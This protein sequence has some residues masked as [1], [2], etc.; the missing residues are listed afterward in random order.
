MR[1]MVLAMALLACAAARADGNLL[2]NAG[3][4]EE[5]TPAWEKRTPDDGQRRIRRVEG[6]GRSGA[7]V[8]LESAAPGQTRL[9]QGHGR[10]IS[11]APGSVVEL[12]AWVR[13]EQDAG[14]ESPGGG[15]L[16]GCSL[17]Q[18]REFGGIAGGDVARVEPAFGQLLTT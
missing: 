16:G 8:A 7:A 10:A 13:S 2:A 6:A 17:R 3:F 9:R 5:L 1:T 4:E 12:S 15:V 14:G 18:F 11:V